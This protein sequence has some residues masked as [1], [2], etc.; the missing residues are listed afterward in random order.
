MKI[1]PELQGTFGTDGETVVGKDPNTGAI[2]TAPDD[3]AVGQAVFDG[4]Y[5]QAQGNLDQQQ[6]RAAAVANSFNTLS[7][8]HA[9]PESRIEALGALGLAV[10]GVVLYGLA[11]AGL[12]TAAAVASAVPVIGL[13]VTAFVAASAAI[14]WAASQIF[15]SASGGQLAQDTP[16]QA[17]LKVI[18]PKM[19]FHGAAFDAQ[20]I[21]ACYRVT[22]AIEA[23]AAG[24]AEEAGGHMLVLSQVLG[25]DRGRADVLFGIVASIV[26]DSR[27]KL[28]RDFS[29]APQYLG[30]VFQT[31][32]GPWGNSFPALATLWGGDIPGQTE[33]ATG[34]GL[35][36]VTG[37]TTLPLYLAMY[38][39]TAVVAGLQGPAGFA[40]TALYQLMIARGWACR[41]SSQAVPE[42]E[43]RCQGFLLD[44][45]ARS[46][47][48]RKGNLG[49]FAASSSRAPV[50]VKD[51]SYFIGYYL[52]E[53]SKVPATAQALTSA[54]LGAASTFKRRI[55]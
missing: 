37:G 3:L 20:A 34:A 43:L 22:S 38:A 47:M 48:A 8:S 44:A 32:R 7:D 54:E 33:L 36:P 27:W 16:L 25:N 18:P 10:S 26:L 12:L 41:A 52:A 1:P 30:Q 39:S 23:Q 45:I 31:A 55:S 17:V 35:Y 29:N 49:T 24:R 13:C 4:T 11:Q 28:N 21:E 53:L 19:N 6:Q 15:G 2:L 9:S 42:A 14:V 40:Y 46:P 50:L 5:T 51:V